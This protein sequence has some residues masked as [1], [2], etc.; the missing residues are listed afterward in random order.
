M[1]DDRPSRWLGVSQGMGTF[2]D[3]RPQPRPELREYYGC[4]A[5]SAS[6]SV[7]G[8]QPGPTMSPAAQLISSWTRAAAPVPP[9]TPEPE[10]PMQERLEA[11][12][13]SPGNRRYAFT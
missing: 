2:R 9:R 1:E 4:R 7:H 8:P 10:P 12:D 11:A 3:G 13:E 6:T 5:S